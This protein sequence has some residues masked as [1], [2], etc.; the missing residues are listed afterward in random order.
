MIT[1]RKYTLQDGTIVQGG[2]DYPAEDACQWFLDSGASD[3]QPNTLTVSNEMRNAWAAWAAHC[4][5]LWGYEF[6]DHM[7]NVFPVDCMHSAQGAGAGADDGD[8]DYSLGRGPGL[9]RIVQDLM[10]PA[11]RALYEA[12]EAATLDCIPE[13]T[14]ES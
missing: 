14:G 3:H 10:L 7:P 2:L 12:F 1:R 13:S 9:A 6:D 11:A 5:T 4:E 8:R